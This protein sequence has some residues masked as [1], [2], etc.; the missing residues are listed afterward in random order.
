MSGAVPIEMIVDIANNSDA[1]TASFLYRIAKRL[2]VTPTG[3][4]VA[5]TITVFTSSP[6]GVRRNADPPRILSEMK[7]IIKP[8]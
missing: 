3:Q 8:V 2:P 7:Q 5:S 1:Y 4:E 6:A